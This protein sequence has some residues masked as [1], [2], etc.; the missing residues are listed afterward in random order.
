MTLIMDAAARQEETEKLVQKHDYTLY[1]VNGD[2]GLNGTVR[3]HASRITALE[4][5]LAVVCALA[6]AGGAGGMQLLTQFLT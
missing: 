5:K 2:N 4:R 1:G 3:D 6:A